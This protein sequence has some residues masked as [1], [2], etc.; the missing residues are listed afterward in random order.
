MFLQFVSVIKDEIEIAHETALTM[1]MTNLKKKKSRKYQKL[2]TKQDELMLKYS[3]GNIAVFQYQL[4]IGHCSIKYMD[5]HNMDPDPYGIGLDRKKRTNDEE[6][7]EFVDEDDVDDIDFEEMDEDLIM[8]ELTDG[9]T[10][11]I[12]A[13]VIE[14]D[15]DCNVKTKPLRFKKNRRQEAVPSCTTSYRIV[16]SPN[17]HNTFSDSLVGD[18]LRRKRFEDDINESSTASLVTMGI[19][20]ATLAASVWSKKKDSLGNTTTTSKAL[21]DAKAAWSMAHKRLEQTGFRLSPT[22]PKT[23]SDGNCLFWA[24]AD[25]MKRMIPSNSY[26]HVEIRKVCVENISPMLKQ[27]RLVWMDEESLDSWKTRM[28]CDGQFGDEYILQGGDFKNKQTM[29]QL[30][31]QEYY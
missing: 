2:K 5:K 9:I 6:Y 30:F 29:K 3:R 23:R 22:Q 24:L 7:W 8:T 19:T 27:K 10:E 31:E 4:A 26:S 28:A 17:C 13:D 25:N 11:T 1:I 18:E 14:L 12:Q 21:P 16:T 15:K 20:A